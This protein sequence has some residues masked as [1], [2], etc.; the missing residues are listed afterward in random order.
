M[1]PN[2]SQEIRMTKSQEQTDTACCIRDVSDR[3]RRG[4]IA[5][6]SWDVTSRDELVHRAE[7]HR[8]DEARD[9]ATHFIAW[10]GAR[11]NGESYPSGQKQENPPQQS[12]AEAGQS[13][14]KQES[15]VRLRVHVFTRVS[16]ETPS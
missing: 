2:V 9:R 4:A 16:C 1:H 12:A 6:M 11:H 7:Y 14:E 5:Y 15:G 3:R 10:I 8:R 13:R